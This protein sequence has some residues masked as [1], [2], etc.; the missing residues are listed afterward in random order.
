MSMAEKKFGFRRKYVSIVP[1]AEWYAMYDDGDAV[2][3]LPVVVWAACDDSDG[4]TG[5]VGLVVDDGF[6]ELCEAG[7]IAYFECYLHRA[8]IQAR[9]ARYETT[10]VRLPADPTAN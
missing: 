1:A 5:V 3:L 8:E 9:L 10:Q 7:D 6:P 4:G 2:R